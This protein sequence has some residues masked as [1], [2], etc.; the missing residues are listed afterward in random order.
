MVMSD[1]GTNYTIISPVKDEEKY[2]ETTIRSVLRQTVRP[3]RRVIVDDRS[4]DKTPFI[5]D[6]YRQM[7]PWITT[8]RLVRDADRQPG[9]AVMQAFAKGYESVRDLIFDFKVKLD[10]D[11]DLPPNYFEQLIAKF[12]EDERLEAIS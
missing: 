10:C 11:L 9:S 8:L 6:R 2:I 1:P 12:H 4:R 7:L 3:S 5:A